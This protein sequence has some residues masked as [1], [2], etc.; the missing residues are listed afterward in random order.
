MARSGWRRLLGR[1]VGVDAPLP[2]DT[3]TPS[4]PAADRPAEPRLPVDTSLVTEL[5]RPGDHGVDVVVTV[6]ETT[7]RDGGHRAVVRA[8]RDAGAATVVVSVYDVHAGPTSVYPAVVAGADHVVARATV[9]ATWGGAVAAARPLLTSARVV[10]QDASVTMPLEAYATL[11]AALDRAPVA[12]GVVRTGDDL[13]ASA[14]A[15]LVRGTAPV[16]ALLRG[17]PAGDADL[18]DGAEVFAADEPCFAVRTA[19]LALPVRTVDTRTAVAR[20]TRDSADAGG[21]PCVVVALGRVYRTRVLRERRYDTDAATALTHWRTRVD[22]T[23]ITA[24]ERAGLVPGLPA[25]DPAGA[26]VALREPVV[27]A[28]RGAERVTL[29]DRGE[30]LR[31]S[32]R[33]AAHPGPGGDDW[34]DTFFARD[35]ATALRSLGQEVVV[36]HRESHVRPLSEHLDDVAL[37]LRGLD[38]TPVHPVATNVLWVIS[39]PDL[40]TADELA[41]YDLRFAAGPVW[42]A[43]VAADTGLDV[44]P[45]LQATDPTRFHPGPGAPEYAG[46]DTAFVGKTR[47]VFRP[48]VR[49]AVAAGLDLA[50][51]GEGWEGLLPEGVHRGVF[52]ANEALPSLYRSARVVLNDHWDDMARD[53]FV[54]NRLFDAAATGALVLTDPVPGVDELFHGAVRTYRDADELRGLVH[55]GETSSAAER[56]ERGTRV[57]AEHS[58]VRRAEVLLEAVRRQRAGGQLRGERPGASR[59]AG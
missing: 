37:T 51:W 31:W 35:L 15:V 33:I 23:A 44:A 19:D 21:G 9:A 28:E 24:L 2:S 50:V 22:G 1:P 45:L 6:A 27:R 55:Q 14:G 10:V 52:V 4:A 16:A 11:T 5:S 25:A 53:G 48:V 26:P 18:L 43:R 59:A 56:A 8:A 42:A 47:Q 36:D 30:R 46:L 41:R 29:R 3:P 7:F 38:D 49:D 32:I 54:S 20:L 12:V 17:H 58:F 34:G 57:G 13:V 39:H 40:V